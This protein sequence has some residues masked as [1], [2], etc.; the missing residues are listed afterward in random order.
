M[1]AVVFFHAHPADQ[2]PWQTIKTDPVSSD[3]PAKLPKE[4]AVNPQEVPQPTDVPKVK[5]TKGQL[6]LTGSPISYGRAPYGI[7]VPKGSGMTKPLQDAIAGLCADR[8]G[9]A[10]ECERA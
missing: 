9:T 7:A 5:Q 3:V 8:G 10:Q 6:K 4:P 1:S 2:A